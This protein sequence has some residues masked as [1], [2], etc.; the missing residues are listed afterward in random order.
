MTANVNINNTCNA[1]LERD[2][3]ERSTSTRSGGGCRNTGELAAVFDHEWGHG[4][5]DNDAAGVLSNPSEGYADIAGIYRLHASCVGHG[6]SSGAAGSCGLT[7]DGTGPNRNENQT[8]GSHCDLD[9]S[10]VRDAD[11]DKHADHNPDTPLNFV[12]GACL[13]GPGPCGRQVHCSAAPVRQAAWDLVT[14][15]LPAAGFSNESSF[16]IGNKLFYQGS[17]NIGTWYSCTCSSSQNGC[18]G[19][20][21]Y[22]QW[23]A[24]DDTDGNINNGT[25]HMQQIFDAYNRHGIACSSPTP[26]NSGCTSPSTA[27]TLS[28]GAGENSAA[29]SWNG[30]TGASEYWVMRTEGHAGCDFGKAKIA[31]VT[32]TSFTDT[33]VAGGREYYYNVVAA[34]TSDACFTQASNCVPVTPTMP[35]AGAPTVTITNPADGSSFG[36]GDTINFIGTAIDPQDGDISASIVWNSSLDNDFGTGAVV[37]TSTLSVGNHTITASAT[38]SDTL[39]GS[40]QISISILPGCDTI[41]YSAGFETDSDGW[42]TGPGQ[43]CSTG[44]F[45]RGTPNEIINGGVTTQV[46]G[47]SV[48]TF[49]WFTQPNSAAGTDDVDGGTCESLSPVIN[50]GSDVSVFVDYFHGQRDAGDDASDGF[51]I[52]LIDASTSAV[53][54]NLVSFGDVTNNAVWTSLSG[55]TASAPSQV[56]LRVRATD[57]AGAGDLVEGGVDAI[58]VC[59]GGCT[60]NDDCNDNLFCNGVETCNL[61][62]GS[63]QAGTPPDC[64][65]TVSCTVD[66]CNETTDSCDHVPDDGVCDN[67]AFC[68]GTETCHATL[69]CQA[70]TAVD[71]DDTIACTADSC[72][73]G[74]DSCDNVPDDA[75]CDDTLF[76]N[77]AEV[78]TVG[79]GCEDGP[80]PC[81]GSQTCNEDDDVCEGGGGC[82]HGADFEGGAGG[83]IDN[84]NGPNGPADPCSTGFFVVGA[85]DATTWQVGGGNPGNAFFT[86]PNP[87]GIGTDDVDNGTCEALSPAVDCAGQAAADVSLDYYH[88]QRDNADGAGD[89]LII[90]VLNNGVVVDTMVSIGDVTNN[91]A[92]TSVSTTVA[93]PGNIQVRVRA[94]D[95]TGSGDIVEGGID[96]VVIAPGVPPGP[97]TVDDDFEAGAPDWVHEPASTCTTGIYIT[98]NPTNPGG[99]QIVGSHS[100]V[101]SIFTATNTSGGVNDV[102][103]GNCILGSP[104]TPWSVANASTLSV[105]YWHGQRDNADDP[106]GGLPNGDGFALEYSID[107]GATWITLA[108][109]GDSPSTAV[110]T[111]ATAAIPAGSTVRLRMQCSD[112]SAAGDLV[113]CGIDDFSICE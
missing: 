97:C 64:S 59:S 15:D 91:P 71:C 69:G 28:V 56:R 33:E 43:T 113:E 47:A 50:V 83:W 6:F 19:S 30:V 37:S 68:D 34:G 76:C 9:C 41:A 63:C 31:E 106:N 108:S 92:W 53:V 109:N 84:T 44:T 80:D 51:S 46:G 89:G 38:D 12:C 1:F 35:G 57:A 18:G 110:W 17:G 74:T 54:L 103:G 8:G 4:L 42:T 72:N 20:G 111:E 66:S 55:S 40:D 85:P 29:L 24:A 86:Q 23:L 78:C 73:E 2:L 65:D 27:P 48:G 101:T 58:Q 99:V 16:I 62:T 7:L 94:T 39:T 77:G 10:G 21:G 49:A 95:D 70:G 22:L 90:E 104:A 112:G 88:G 52:D 14:R 87:G 75:V 100:G 81:S 93:N 107:N 25:P 11:W 79:V 32:G 5:D 102:D 67:G 96:N 26:T 60:S 3:P 105:W 98:G 82:S 13:T 36:D 61:G 45:V